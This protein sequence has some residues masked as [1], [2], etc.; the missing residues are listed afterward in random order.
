MTRSLP[1]WV[2]RNPPRAAPPD[3]WRSLRSVRVPPVHYLD[4]LRRPSLGA[5]RRVRI[6]SA[7][8]SKLGQNST[9]VDTS[10]AKLNLGSPTGGC[11]GQ[12]LVFRRRQFIDSN[13]AVS[14]GTDWLPV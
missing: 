10:V 8:H 2:H 7:K 14:F 5:T 4:N 12:A 11:R 6:Q 1:S 13:G 3:S 9:G